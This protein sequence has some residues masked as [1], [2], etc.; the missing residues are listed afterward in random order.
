MTPEGPLRATPNSGA[1]E[2]RSSTPAARA[3]VRVRLG[4]F[5]LVGIVLTSLVVC[6]SAANTGVLLPES[7]RPV[8]A[9]LAGPFG[10]GGPN[11]RVGVLMGLLTA[12]FGCYLLVM[13]AAD[14][15]SARHVLMAIA[16]LYTLVLLA[17]PLLSTDVFS[18][19]AYGRMW[20]IYGANPYLNGPHV[21]FYDQLYPYIGAKWVNTPTSYGPLFTLL[22]LLLSNLSGNANVA[23]AASALAYK[24]IATLACL[25]TIAL[26]WNAARLRG[27]NPVRAVALF[28]LNPLVVLYG[29]GGGHNDLLMLLF[30]TAGIY[31]LLSR[32]ERTS[33]ALVAIGAGIKL[34]ALLL[35]PFALVSGVEKGASRRRRSILVGAA[36]TSAAIGLVGFVVFGTGEFNLLSTLRT[37]QQEGD[38]H[39]IPG[40]LSEGLG[41]GGVSRITGLVLGLIFVVVF[42][43]LVRRVWQN[44]MDWIDGAGWATFAMLLTASSLLPWYVAWLLPLVGLCTDRRL[45]RYSLVLTGWML[46]ITMIGYL[47]HGSS[48]LGAL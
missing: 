48:V 47:P 28:A 23:I 40:F 37:V 25:G 38:W 41:L 16:A 36:A 5:G 39:S 20:E 15:L 21:L 4:L 11:L 17:P 43:W 29:V 19:Q 44:K 42:V 30:T 24:A 46:L 13:R 31:A 2:L 12:M 32:R 33:G 8:P 9:F 35:L 22:S 27:L 14:R 3:V 26:L 6:V 7:V 18:Y 1:F 10:V 34:T 45:W